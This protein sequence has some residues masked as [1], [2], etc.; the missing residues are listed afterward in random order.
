MRGKVIERVFVVAVLL[1]GLSLAPGIAR[2]GWIVEWTN[3]AIKPNGDRMTPESATMYIDR[4]RV[5][6][7]QPAVTTVI[8][9]DKGLF[10]ILNPKQMFFWSGKTDEYL[11]EMVKDRA[12]AMRERSGRGLAPDYGMRDIDE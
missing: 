12:Q 5:R 11:S 4:N 7:E 6:V 1:V 9:Y 2:G 3:T 8:D 10:T